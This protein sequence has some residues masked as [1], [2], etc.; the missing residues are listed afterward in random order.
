MAR[1]YVSSE[2]FL[3]AYLRGHKAGYTMEQIAEELGMQKSSAT[4]KASQLRQKGI[5]L[6][7]LAQ[8]RQ[9]LDL[10]VLAKMVQDYEDDLI[11]LD[12][13]HNVTISDHLDEDVPNDTEFVGFPQQE[14]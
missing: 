11:D 12:G 5:K 14:V 6:P 3:A 13:N 4:V 10:G 1:N 8:S 7:K 9:K 2:V